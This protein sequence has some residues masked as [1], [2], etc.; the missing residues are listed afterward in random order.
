MITKK[1]YI[2]RATKNNFEAINDTKANSRAESMRLA[3]DM[4]ETYWEENED[5]I[6]FNE[7]KKKGEY[8]K[9]DLWVHREPKYW[10][11]R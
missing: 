9:S 3:R 5:T 2:K 4:A 11:M 10:R 6:K 8:K 7:N 1:E